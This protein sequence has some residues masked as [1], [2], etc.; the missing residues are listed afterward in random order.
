MDLL[1]YVNQLESDD[2]LFIKEFNQLRNYYDIKQE[3]EVYNFV[4]NHRGLIILLKE[5]Q[6]HLI[7]NFPNS[8]FSLKYSVDPEFDSLSNLILNVKVDRYTFE[9]GVM[10]TIRKISFELRPLRQKLDLMVE[11]MLMPALLDNEK[12]KK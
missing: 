5:I 7:K 4:N 1:S 2:D 12:F 6:P 10:K 8:E 11:L 3:F 9:N